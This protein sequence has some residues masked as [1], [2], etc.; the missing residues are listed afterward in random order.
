MLKDKKSLRVLVL[1][2]MHP[3]DS[4]SLHSFFIIFQISVS[5][6]YLYIVNYI[7][8]FKMGCVLP[9]HLLELFT[10]WGCAHV[11]ARGRLVN[12]L[13]LHHVDARDQTQVVRL[14]SKHL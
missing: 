2:F 12:F 8:I 1:S 10:V 6:V 14:R 3:N 13:S 4:H 11:G 5:H 9:L 7:F